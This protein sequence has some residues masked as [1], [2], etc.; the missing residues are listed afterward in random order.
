MGF[1]YNTESEWRDGTLSYLP[2]SLH[3]VNKHQDDLKL[4]RQL[5]ARQ[6]NAWREFVQRFQDLV[7]ARV[8]QTLERSRTQ[9]DR[10]DI[11]DIFAE[12]F[13][14]L[15]A[16]DFRSLR[17][18]R[19]ESSLATWL[20]VVAQRVCIRQAQKLGRE[21]TNI[22]DSRP[23]SDLVVHAGQS[24][25]L[26]D[27]IQKEDVKRLKSKLG[28]LEKN[29]QKILTLYFFEELG[30]GEISQ[31]MGISINSVGPKLQR[32]RERLRKLMRFS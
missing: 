25:G 20:A 26:H 21:R 31:R 1:R 18:F 16:N 12:V 8:H 14:S 22:A 30:Y 19:G 3:V 6:K 29:D 4:V 28:K 9:Y 32:A 2:A 5:L 10:S 23:L 11:E 27:L 7:Y 17:N 24:E 15:L 13:S